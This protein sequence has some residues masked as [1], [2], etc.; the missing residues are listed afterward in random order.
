GER[1]CGPADMSDVV[2]ASAPKPSTTINGVNVGIP[3]NEIHPWGSCR[4][5]DF[6]GGPLGWV[7]VSCAAGTRIVRNGMLFGWC[8]QGG[9]PGRLGCPTT[10]EYAFA[11]GAR[12]DFQHGSLFWEPGWDHARPLPQ[13]PGS[14]ANAAIANYL[15]DPSRLN[16]NLGVVHGE[17]R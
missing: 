12:Q 14:F 17:C 9:A 4:V 16:H 6:K 2:V 10:D 8:D 15:L 5:R 11:G 13:G 1:E 7:I 3:Q